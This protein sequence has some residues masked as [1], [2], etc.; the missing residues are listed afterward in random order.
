MLKF[1][2]IIYLVIILFAFGCAYKPILT[3]KNYE[4]SIN[5]TDKEGNEKINKFITERLAYLENNNN[6]KI[7]QISLESILDKKIISKDSKGDPSIFETDITTFINVKNKEG[8]KFSRTINKKNTYNNKSDKFEL[9]Q[10]EEILIK[11]ASQNIAE[12]ILS[13]LSNL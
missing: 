3:N 6:N 11:N 8:K 7:F 5:F 2:R 9:D 10:Y 12:E 13:Y 4:F 1:N